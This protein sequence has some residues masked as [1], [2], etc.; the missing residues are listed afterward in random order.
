MDLNIA[1]QFG[2]LVD[3]AYAVD[4]ADLT[5]QAGKI[6]NAGLIGGG[7]AYEV[8]TSIYAND[9]ATDLNPLRGNNRVSIGLV[10]QASA[11]GDTVI[12]IRGT[13]GIKE[14]V[15]D[16][17]FLNV[18]CPFLPGAGNTEDGFTA[19]YKSMTMGAAAGSPAALQ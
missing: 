4:P 7:V 17:K 12:A 15:Q 9:I 10:L 13:D 11:P 8:V 14:W 19:M 6:V 16:A 5:N 3:A 18:P 1:I 2:Q